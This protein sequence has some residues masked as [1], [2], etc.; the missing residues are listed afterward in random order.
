MV[1][2]CVL[3]KRLE[4]LRRGKSGEGEAGGALEGGN[5]LKEWSRRLWRPGR[6]PPC[7][8]PGLLLVRTILTSAASFTLAAKYTIYVRALTTRVCHTRGLIDRLGIGRRSRRYVLMRSR[9]LSV[10]MTGKFEQL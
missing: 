7:S 10:V 3:D 8:G 4:L 2:G 1:V 9:W 5:V 6:R